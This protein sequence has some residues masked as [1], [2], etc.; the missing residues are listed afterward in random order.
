MTYIDDAP[1]SAAEVASWLTVDSTFDPPGFLE[2]RNLLSTL[3]RDIAR[4]HLY[5][6]P[7]AVIVIDLDGFGE[8]RENYG[9]FADQVMALVGR[10]LRAGI[11]DAD[12]ICSPYTALLLGGVFVGQGQRN[13][14]EFIIGAPE[15]DAVGVRALIESLRTEVGRPIGSG[16]ETTGPWFAPTSPKALHRSVQ[17]SFTAGVA[18]LEPEDDA[19]SMLIRAAGDMV[20]NKPRAILGGPQ[21]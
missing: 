3:E 9:D 18:E 2:P 12:F 20:N 8:V 1:A 5:G 7:F 4:S 13:T 17:V 16:K 21:C 14:D 19:I 11:T 10:R 6:R 15:L